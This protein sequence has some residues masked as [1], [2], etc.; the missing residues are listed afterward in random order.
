MKVYINVTTTSVL[1]STILCLINIVLSTTTSSSSTL[2][3][4]IIDELNNEDENNLIIVNTSVSK[5]RH[6]DVYESTY[7][8]R[9]SF[10]FH[11]HELPSSRI[12]FYRYNVLFNKP[13]YINS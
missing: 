3:L 6:Y 1:I 4:P 12:D 9:P 10:H 8:I 2:L 7:K 5:H 13:M 11:S